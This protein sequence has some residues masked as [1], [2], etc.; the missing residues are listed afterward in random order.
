MN[1]FEIIWHGCSPSVGFILAKFHNSG[2]LTANYKLIIMNYLKKQ[3]LELKFNIVD[4]PN[5]I[6]NSTNLI[7]VINGNHELNAPNIPKC[8]SQNS[9][10]NTEK[11]SFCLSW[12][13]NEWNFVK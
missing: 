7:N 1:N 3:Y 5:R 11:F 10:S 9:H 13:T 4:V 6:I 2:Y 8:F 12:D